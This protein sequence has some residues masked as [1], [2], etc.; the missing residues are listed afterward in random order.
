VCCD[1]LALYSATILYGT[2]KFM[3]KSLVSI[4]SGSLHSGLCLY[5]LLNCSSCNPKYLCLL[6]LQMSIILSPVGQ[7]D[8][9][10]VGLPCVQVRCVSRQSTVVTL[11]ETVD[12]KKEQLKVSAMR[13]SALGDV[14]PGCKG[15]AGEWVEGRCITLRTVSVCS[16]L[17]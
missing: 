6:L 14:S 10:I 7:S 17:L 9:S 3:I 12:A 2:Y 16:E 11:M 8:Q 13:N 4:V 1:C 5:Y 15:P